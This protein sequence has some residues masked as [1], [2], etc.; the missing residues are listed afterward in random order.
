MQGTLRCVMP[1][2]A[3]R[4]SGDAQVGRCA[5]DV[6][7]RQ[8]RALS[9]AHS[10]SRAASVGTRRIRP[11]YFTAFAVRSARVTHFSAMQTATQS[12]R[13]CSA[14]RAVAARR[15]AGVPALAARSSSAAQGGLLKLSRRA[16]VAQ[17][18]KANVVGADLRESG[19]LYCPGGSTAL[20]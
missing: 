20:N 5:R 1:V 3:A 11:R 18:A 7:S 8:W 16:N 13:L 2:H 14:P 12:V 6:C 10:V 17:A 15:V 4:G 9:Q 19:P